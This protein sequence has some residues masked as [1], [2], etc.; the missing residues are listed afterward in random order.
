VRGVELL[1]GRVPIDHAHHRANPRGPSKRH[2]VNLTDQGYCAHGV[3]G[4]SNRR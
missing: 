1:R 3:A 2:W 4:R